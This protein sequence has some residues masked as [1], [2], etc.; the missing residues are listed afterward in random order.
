MGSSA[1]NLTG[2]LGPEQFRNKLINGDFT[3][4]Q[5]GA[6]ATGGYGDGAGGG[7]TDA[8]FALYHADRW[9][10]NAG[11]GRGFEDIGITSV[12]RISVKRQGFT[13]GQ[14]SLSDVSGSQYFTRVT[15]GAAN[16]TSVSGVTG[17]SMGEGNSYIQFFQAVE[18]NDFGEWSGKTVWLSFLA[19]SYG[20]ITHPKIGCRVGLNPDHSQTISGDT[21]PDTTG[22]TASA[23]SGFDDGFKRYSN[24]V[25]D[26]ISLTP[27]WQKFKRKFV[28]PDFTGVTLGTGVTG[29]VASVAPIFVLATGVSGPESFYSKTSVTDYLGLTSGFTGAFDVAQVQLE[30][31]NDVSPFEKRHPHVELA[32]CQRYYEKTYNMETALGTNTGYA[33]GIRAATDPSINKTCHQTTTFMVPKRTVPTVVLYS[34]EGKIGKVWPVHAENHQSTNQSAT[35]SGISES[36]FAKIVTSNDLGNYTRGDTLIVYHYTADAEL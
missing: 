16:G 5:R 35:A 24:I 23:T 15:I 31:G 9:K 8:G 17:S 18:A 13:M 7:G 32:M 10:I 3:F 25:G 4:W 29:N 30:I 1:I 21:W 36:G 34:K 11:V 14:P 6:G 28:L 19:K 12:P 20:N 33:G 27:E 22:V 26:D 2:P